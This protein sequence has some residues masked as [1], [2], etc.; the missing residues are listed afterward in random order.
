MAFSHVYLK[1]DKAF[2]CAIG[3]KCQRF[4]VTVAK[5]TVS[6]SLCP[7]ERISTILSVRVTA[8]TED[9]SEKSTHN[10]RFNESQWM[11]KTSAYLYEHK[12]LDV[13]KLS[14]KAIERKI[15][16]ISEKSWPKHFEPNEENCVV[17]SG[18]LG[19]P[20]K[21]QG[22]YFFPHSTL[23]EKPASYKVF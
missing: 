23:R 5:K 8:D 18:P 1:S 20:V 13:S 19:P 4:K 9:S 15:L 6:T 3:S 7:H 2:H 10:V 16:Q 17:C 22:R 21:H 14:K 11:S 12:K